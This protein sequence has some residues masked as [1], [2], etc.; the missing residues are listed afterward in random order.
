MGDIENSCCFRHRRSGAA[1]DYALDNVEL[2]GGELLWKL[3]F[4]LRNAGHHQPE[5]TA[6]LEQDGTHRLA[7]FARERFKAK[8][9]GRSGIGTS[10]PREQTA[11]TQDRH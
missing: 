11:S 4:P 8:V 5:L 6:G 9:N 10:H 7:R 3:W 2:R 1:R